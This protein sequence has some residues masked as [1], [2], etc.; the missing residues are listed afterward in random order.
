MYVCVCVC[1]CVC[2]Y[3][4]IHIYDCAHTSLHARTQ[5]VDLFTFFPFSTAYTQLSICL[6]AI[7]SAWKPCR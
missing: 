7:L 5:A 6:T 4:P 2:V 3:T 1:V